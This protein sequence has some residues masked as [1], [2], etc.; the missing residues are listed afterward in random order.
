MYLQIN[1]FIG[2]NLFAYWTVP[3]YFEMPFTP[4]IS[5]FEINYYPEL[6]DCVKDHSKCFGLCLIAKLA[7]KVKDTL[8]R[9]NQSY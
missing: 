5:Y 6:F 3:V 1:V 9:Q 2:I 8:Q 4:A 7:H